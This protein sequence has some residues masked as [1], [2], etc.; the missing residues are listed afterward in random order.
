ME[1]LTE[2]VS[3]D[4]TPSETRVRINE[5]AVINLGIFHTGLGVIS[6]C[7]C[8]SSVTPPISFQL[9][10]QIPGRKMDKK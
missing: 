9:K 1:Q 4:T 2:S 7:P 6:H 5:C 10:Q 8:S 3:T